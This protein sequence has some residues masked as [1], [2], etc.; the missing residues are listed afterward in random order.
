MFSTFSTNLQEKAATSGPRP[1]R[2]QVARACD[3]CRLN[4]IK[5]DD[6][7]P[8][9]NCRSRGGQCSNTKRRVNE[10]QQQLENA[11]KEAQAQ[12]SAKYVTPPH[13]TD[14]GCPSMQ[15][16]S[17]AA[18]SRKGWE[19]VQ[20]PDAQTGQVIYFG[21]LSSSYFGTRVSRYLAEALKSSHPEFEWA[22]CAGRLSY[23]PSPWSRQSQSQQDQQS[24]WNVNADFPTNAVSELDEDVEDLSRAQEEYFLDLLWQSFHCVYP[25][26]A[27]SEFRE[28]YDSLWDADDSIPRRPS[29]LVDSLLAVC[30][31]YGSTFLMS[32]GDSRGG[33]EG[34]HAANASMTGHAF[35]RRSQHLL[36]NELE[37]PSVMT[38]QSYLYS[39]IYLSN[40]ALLNTAHTLLGTALRVAQML[41][42]HLRPLDGTP[43]RQ[44]ELHRRI[45]W[46]LYQVDSQLSMA[47]GRPPL[48]QRGE[49]EVNITKD[50]PEY[51]FMSGSMLLCPSNEDIS[52]LSFHAQCVRLVSTVRCAQ[53]TF[54]A[55]CAQ[56]VEAKDSQDIYGDP[57]MIEELAGFLGRE[58]RAVY[59][60]VRNVPRS[61]QN[62]RKG[63]GEPFSTERT[64]LNL[65]NLSPIWLQRQRLLLE[66]LYHHLQL[67]N[68]RPFLRFPPGGSSITPLADCHSITC[69]N[70]AISLTNI[71]HQVLSETDLLRGWSPIFQYQWDAARC[72]MGFVLS[73]PVCP[74]SPTARKFMHTAIG[75]FDVMGHYS[76]AA[77][78]AALIVRETGAYA[79]MLVDRFHNSLS[80]RRPTPRNSA[81]PSNSSLFGSSTTTQVQNLAAPALTPEYLQD[82]TAASIRA[83][84]QL[85]VDAPPFL[86]ENADISLDQAQPGAAVTMAMDDSLV[87][88][89]DMLSGIGEDWMPNEGGA[90]LNIGI[91]FLGSI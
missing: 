48:I 80:L 21:P 90:L 49:I 47:L 26:I 66:L 12:A 46:T 15:E 6:S 45:W 30:M 13:S 71:L 56:L 18:S 75:N 79:E 14:A 60:W 38:M 37:S 3:W 89:E 22:K 54:Q 78:E 25:I 64:P 34:Y 85:T 63:S 83:I 57:Y 43:Q 74:P 4:R 32:D 31:Q 9:Q 58:V 70:H 68:F 42:L 39:I 41:R 16:E 52:W 17:F 2:N 29:S 20:S 91:T 67:S 82:L 65:D 8:C 19:G 69:L 36:L 55:R 33:D 59:D 24:C 40:T 77:A 1:K 51:A 87:L 35:Y 61:L 27:E 73:N 5:C 11:T 10:L 23:P 53:N 76:A 62:T 88:S 7:L 50:G 81:T 28:Y 84:P 44:Q 72:I 86:K